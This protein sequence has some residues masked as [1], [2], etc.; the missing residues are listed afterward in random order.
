MKAAVIFDLDGTLIDSRQVMTHAFVEAFRRTVGNGEPP[1][2]EFRKLLGDSLSNILDILGLPPHMAVVFEEIS[3]KNS[4]KIRV[5][6][7]AVEICRWLYQQ[8]I[9]RAIL[10]GKDRG[11]TIQILNQF[12]L[13]EL[14]NIVATS[15]DPFRPKPSPEGVLWIADRLRVSTTRMCMVGDSV[16]DISAAKAVGMRAIGC[17]WGIGD[18]CD[19]SG[20]G[21]DHIVDTPQELR[22]LLGQWAVGLEAMSAT[23][24]AVMTQLKIGER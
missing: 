8:G 2:A 10:T 16:N 1:L 5:H 11:R 18:R 24:R 9:S 3:R 13:T 4:M 21:A 20:S 23:A 7:E 19:L 22:V 15:S 17:A 12:G 6:T 14:F